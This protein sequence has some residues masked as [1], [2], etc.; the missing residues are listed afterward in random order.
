MIATATVAAA[1]L[2]QFDRAPGLNVAG[3]FTGHNRGES[4]TEWPKGL[5]QR[6]LDLRDRQATMGPRHAGEH[7]SG[8]TAPLGFDRASRIDAGWTPTTSQ[9]KV[10]HGRHLRYCAA[11]AC[12]SMSDGRGG[13]RGY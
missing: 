10:R 9:L 8:V 11:V 5:G 6:L 7:R 1:G 4:D 13:E 12:A 3:K 2:G